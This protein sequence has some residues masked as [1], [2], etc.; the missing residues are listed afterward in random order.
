[1]YTWQLFSLLG[2]GA[3]FVCYFGCLFSGLDIARTIVISICMGFMCYC[4]GTGKLLTFAV[5]CLFAL[6]VCWLINTYCAVN[7]EIDDSVLMS[8]DAAGLWITGFMLAS[9]VLNGVFKFIAF[10]V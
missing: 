3:F 10:I 9:V 8:F 7:T 2:I 1:M 4:M 5:G 6:V